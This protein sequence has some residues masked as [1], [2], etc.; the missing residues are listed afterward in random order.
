MKTIE[1][2]GECHNNRSGKKALRSRSGIKGEELT[3]EALMKA[4]EN[5]VVHAEKARELQKYADYEH[6]NEINKSYDMN[7]VGLEVSFNLNTTLHKIINYELLDNQEKLDI[8]NNKRTKTELQDLLG[9]IEQ[10]PQND[11]KPTELQDKQKTEAT[12]ESDV[13]HSMEENATEDP[14]EKFERWAK[15]IK[16]TVMQSLGG[17][18]LK[19]DAA[20]TDI[21]SVTMASNAM[22]AANNA[23]NDND[24]VTCLVGA[25]HVEGMYNIIKNRYGDKCTLNVSFALDLPWE[26]VTTCLKVVRSNN[27]MTSLMKSIEDGGITKVELRLI[28]E[29]IARM[30]D[31][32]D[33]NII[34]SDAER[35]VTKNEID[36][37][38]TEELHDEETNRVTNAVKVNEALIHSNL[39]LYLA[40]KKVQE[41]AEIEKQQFYNSL[42]RMN[43]ADKK[44][45]MKAKFGAEK[46]AANIE[47]YN[48][49]KKQRMLNQGNSLY[50]PQTQVKDEN[51]NQIKK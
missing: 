51:V 27:G 23:D 30:V 14:I 5:P 29:Y 9:I 21:R 3:P 26:I 20:K 25:A 4:I 49:Q 46:P 10:I 31:H 12:K 11:S 32:V 42:K 19:D 39:S 7:H 37:M 40:A 2:I 13:V 8:I 44:K 15:L 41:A 43:T 48:P 18:V 6:F 47:E 34:T 35:L 45:Q 28:L 38:I 22:W 16:E 36:G 17:W 24:R 1:I 50:I 33:I